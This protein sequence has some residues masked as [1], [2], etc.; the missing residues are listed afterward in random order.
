MVFIHIFNN[1]LLNNLLNLF[2]ILSIL[3]LKKSMKT[4]IPNCSICLEDIDTASEEIKICLIKCCGN[5]YHY[6]CIID[7][8][9]KKQ[10]CPLCQKELN[11]S[12]NGIIIYNFEDG[13]HIEINSGN[14]EYNN[15]HVIF[16]VEAPS[17]SDTTALVERQN[18]YCCY[19]LKILLHRLTL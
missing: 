1:K 19:I 18:T 16:N 5:I 10:I 14:L 7:W 17:I 15:N 2:N 4:E 13:N 9:I 12:E 8:F 6:D 11:L 3:L